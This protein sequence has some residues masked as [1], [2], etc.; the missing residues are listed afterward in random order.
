[1]GKCKSGRCKKCN[2]HRRGR[3]VVKKTTKC[4]GPNIPATLAAG[5]GCAMNGAGPGLALG[6]CGIDTDS[7]LR[8]LGSDLNNDYHLHVDNQGLIYAH[9]HRHLE[10]HSHDPSGKDIYLGRIA[11]PESL[12][13]APDLLNVDD[14]GFGA[15]ACNNTL[16]QV[17][18]ASSD[19]RCNPCDPRPADLNRFLTRASAVNARTCQMPVNQ[20]P[21]S[22]QVPPP[23][24]GCNTALGVSQP[25][26]TVTALA[27]VTP[28]LTTTSP[29]L[30]PT[31]GATAP[32]SVG[33]QAGVLTTSNAL[34]TASPLYAASLSPDACQTAA[35]G[36]GNVEGPRPYGGDVT[37]GF[38]FNA[39]NACCCRLTSQNVCQIRSLTHCGLQNTVPRN[40]STLPPQALNPRSKTADLSQVP[41]N[42]VSTLSTALNRSTIRTLPPEALNPL[43]RS[44]NLLGFTNTNFSTLTSALG[45][46]SRRPTVC[47]SKVCEKIYC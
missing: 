44:P 19:P 43:G 25:S 26:T 2:K 3:R 8:C 1:M 37:G 38:D 7:A 6:G 23:T 46:S 5:N 32:H 33:G 20:Q 27:T 9:S 16:S 30:D 24:C 12:T 41:N 4:R 39:T 15:P 36:V 47:Q 11:G 35:L 22:L 31:C 28:P 14:V 40:E 17:L 45:V 29:N 42:G 21:V 10:A 18:S 34:N 13:T